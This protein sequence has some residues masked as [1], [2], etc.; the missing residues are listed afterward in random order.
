MAKTH[1]KKS[2]A[3][4][5]DEQSRLLILGS[6]PGDR[7]LQLAEYYGHPQNRFWKLIAQLTNTKELDSYDMKLMML[8]KSGIALWDVAHQANRPGS[9][10]SSMSGEIPNDIAGFI[11]THQKIRAI[12]F[13]GRKAEQ[14]YARHF[15]Y[16][17]HI[18]YYS[19]PSTSPANAGYSFEKLCNAWQIVT[20]HFNTETL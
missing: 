16:L 14:L 8:K 1:L 20:L 18:H 12:A 11:H 6:M 9:M 13:N 17:P 4:I 7:S 3:P 10:D 2:F 19:L 15:P 5:A